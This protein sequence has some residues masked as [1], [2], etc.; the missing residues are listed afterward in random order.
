MLLQGEGELKILQRLLEGAG[1]SS[2]P[3][4]PPESHMVLGGDSDL[5]L[6]AMVSG[7]ER[8][9]ICDDSQDFIA[10][11]AAEEAEAGSGEAAGE[12]A[13][14]GAPLAGAGSSAAASLASSDGGGSGLGGAAEAGGRDGTRAAAAGSAG[15]GSSSSGG[16]NGGPNGSGRRKSG[17]GGHKWGRAPRGSF[18]VQE[19][20]SR[21]LHVFSRDQLAE[22]WQQEHLTGSSAGSASSE[23]LGMSLDLA[24]LAIMCG[25][26]D[27]LPGMQVGR[28][29]G[30]KEGCGA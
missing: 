7:R 28:D 10:D 11:V 19:G 20:S 27:Y 4:G 22:L 26:N 30:E 3:G 9:F 24:L 29:A 15:G 2:D 25:G 23:V 14:A 5:L 6:M 12:A 21:G 18:E 1:S 17:G 13:G 16:G 8:V